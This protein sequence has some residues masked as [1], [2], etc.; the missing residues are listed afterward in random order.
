MGGHLAKNTTKRARRRSVQNEAKRRMDQD[1]KIE[2]IMREYDVNHSEALDTGELKKLATDVL[3]EFTPMVG[4]VTDDD[5]ELILRLGQPWNEGGATRKVISR[6]EVPK[7]LAVMSLIKEHNKHLVELFERYDKN[8]DE[9]LP[10]EDLQTCLREV[11]GGVDVAADDVKHILYLCGVKEGQ[12]IKLNQFKSALCYWY[13]MK[14]RPVSEEIKETFHA[15]DIH[16]TGTIDRNELKAVMK[17][18]E[19]TM[20]DEDIESLFNQVDVNHNGQI[21]YDEFIDWITAEQDASFRKEVCVGYGFSSNKDPVEA[22]K[23]ATSQ[24]GIAFPTFCFASCT[25]NYDVATVAKAFSQVMAGIDVHGLTSCGNLL[26]AG[27]AE[28]GVGCIVVSAAKGALSSVWEVDPAVASAMLKK[29]APGPTAIIMSTTPGSEEAGIAALAKDFPSIPVYGGTAADNEVKGD[30]KLMTTD[31]PKDSGYS[32]VAVGQGVHFGASMLGPYT[33]TDKIAKVTKSEGRK[34]IELDGKPAL[35]WV[36]DWLGDAVKEQ[37]EKG[38]MILGATADKPI[39][40][41]QGSEF[42]P[43]HCAVLNPADQSVDFF[44]PMPEGADLVVMN[45]SDGPSTGYAACL[46]D[47]F[48]EAV[49][50]LDGQAPKAGLLL[51]CGGMSIAVGDNMV[52]GLSDGELLGKLGKMPL[53]GISVF[54]EQCCMK[55]SGNVQRNLSMGFLLFG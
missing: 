48:D 27:K 31:G 49:K 11:N 36:V 3:N 30:W 12:A 34:V 44:A 4:G 8:K 19:P 23:E 10:F 41:K 15:W 18:I 54:G 47:A 35:P 38:G 6:A 20:N 24:A 45:S 1:G 14:D 55:E 2:A 26:C 21:E 32:F 52:K 43:A 39:C 9:T 28:P 29:K 42:I 22:V 40:V 53:L 46:K 5:I 13:C 7:A 25:V 16:K 33:P 37:A 17:T 50:S 51:Y